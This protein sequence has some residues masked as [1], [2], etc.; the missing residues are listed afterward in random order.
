MKH[1]Y[2]LLRHP[3]ECSINV[4]SNKIL[5]IRARHKEIHCNEIRWQTIYDPVMKL[6]SKAHFQIKDIKIL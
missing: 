6:T 3:V 1:Q 5:A 4:K 2:F